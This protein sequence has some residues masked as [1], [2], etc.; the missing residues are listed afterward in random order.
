MSTK[1]FDVALKTTQ[2]Q[3]RSDHIG[4]LELLQL[5]TKENVK[6][7]K[8]LKALRA[9]KGTSD[10]DAGQESSTQVE[11]DK[12]DLLDLVEKNTKQADE[13]KLLKSRLNQVELDLM[14]SKQ[15]QAA[16]HNAASQSQAEKARK[17]EIEMEEAVFELE[18]QLRA[19]K[20]A[21]AG[22]VGMESEI[23]D[24]RIE[25]SDLAQRYDNLEQSHRDILALNAGF[26]SS[27]SAVQARLS[28]LQKELEQCQEE[29][30]RVEG[31]GDQRLTD[32]QRQ[33]THQTEQNNILKKEL[34]AQA[35]SAYQLQQMNISLRTECESAFASNQKLQSSILGLNSMIAEQKQAFQDLQNASNDDMGE[36]FKFTAPIPH[37]P[38]AVPFVDTAPNTEDGDS[39]FR[40]QEFL[41]LKRENKELKMRLA[42]MGLSS[43]AVHKPEALS[44]PPNS[45]LKAGSGGSGPT[46]CNSPRGS[47]KRQ[48]AGGGLPARARNSSSQKVL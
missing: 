17:K 2:E 37:V 16:T 41:R 33:L 42:D 19:A 8:E 47:T 3:L 22:F 23:Q 31:T 29:K 1:R 27:A 39:S 40:F 46:S 26:S 25:H 9:G 45:Q 12:C 18:G 35:E 24:L 38:V 14:K 48:P 6:L 20:T 5:C 28:A 11:A 13:I 43:G 44:V 7:K 4:T 32:T 15:A 36:T 30:K 10:V 21:L 34:Q